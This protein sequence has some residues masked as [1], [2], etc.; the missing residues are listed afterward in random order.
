M[1]NINSELECFDRISL[2]RITPFLSPY[3]NGGK[4]CEDWEIIEIEF[5]GKF[6]KSRVR[7]NSYFESPTDTGFHLSNITGLEIVAQL[8]I[9]HIHLFLGLEQ[10]SKEIWFV[11]GA[12][13]CVAPIRDPDN[14]VVEMNSDFLR[15]GDKYLVKMKALVSDPLGGRFEYTATVLL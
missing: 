4:K 3:L 6:L 14:I 15:Q 9:I 7:M 12:E 11:K 13:K 5:N 1:K 2:D 8:R 10:K